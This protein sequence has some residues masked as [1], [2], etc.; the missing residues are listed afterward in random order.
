LRTPLLVPSRHPCLSPQRCPA[1]TVWC[2]LSRR[3]RSADSC[4]PVSLRGQT[5]SDGTHDE[6]AVLVIYV[7]LP[8]I[9]ITLLVIDVSLLVGDVSLLVRDVLLFVVDPL[10]Q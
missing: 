2:I 6:E 5:T 3:A 8:V 4:T 1:L 10:L 7:L 9:D